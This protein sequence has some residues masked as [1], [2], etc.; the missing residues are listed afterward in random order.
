MEKENDYCV[1]LVNAN[2]NEARVASMS[3]LKAW[4]E[5]GIDPSHCTCHN[6]TKE[7]AHVFIKIMGMKDM[8]YLWGDP[9]T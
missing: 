9:R 4:V 2:R 7:E 6:V 8:T 1:L 5:A 3:V